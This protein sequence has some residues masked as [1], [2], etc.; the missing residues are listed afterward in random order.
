MRI[1]L[2]KNSEASFI[3]TLSEAGITYEARALNSG[4]V[5]ASGTIIEVIQT[6]AT[7]GAIAAVFV[8]WLKARASRKIILTL[9]GN[10]VVHLEGYSVEQAKELIPLVDHL[11]VID[12][13]PEDK[14]S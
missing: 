5:M 2:F 1:A 3:R 12:T 7:P 10:K 4:S 14:S 13:E 6:I 8:G 9:H 11:A